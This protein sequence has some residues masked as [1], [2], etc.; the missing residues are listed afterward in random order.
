KATWGSI[1]AL[2]Y[3]IIFGA[4]LTMTVYNWLLHVA[5]PTLVSTHVFVNPVIAVILGWLLAN[6]KLTSTTLLAGGIIV[7]AVA[8]II[9]TQWLRKRANV[10]PKSAGQL[11]PTAAVSEE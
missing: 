8:W 11:A 2:L 9:M 1:A 4:L 10:G 5:E 3:L 6:E 7:A